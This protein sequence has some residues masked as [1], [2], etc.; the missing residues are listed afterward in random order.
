MRRSC[1]FLIEEDMKMQ[2]HL[3]H[4]NSGVALI[5]VLGM[6]AILMISAVAFS[7]SMRV[8]RRGASNYRYGVQSR[9]MMWS[10]LA[11]AMRDIDSAM[12]SSV[13]PII[14]PNFDVRVSTGSTERAN[15]LSIDV[16]NSLPLGLYNAK[17][18]TAKPY[19]L[20]ISTATGLQVGRYAYVAV[21]C[22]GLLD[23]NA[24][25]G[26]SHSNGVSPKEIQLDNLKDFL[27][28]SDFVGDRTKAYRYESF[29]ELNNTNLCKRDASVPL[30]N[31]CTYSRSREDELYSATG[32]IAKVDLSGDV[33]AIIS[34][35]T[36]IITGLT[37]C[38]VA[39]A[40]V[41]LVFSNLVDYIDT[42]CIPSDLASPCAEAV[43][44]ISEFFITNRLYSIASNSVRLLSLPFVEICYPFT[45]S[46]PYSFELYLDWKVTMSNLTTGVGASTEKT[47]MA[48]SPPGGSYGPLDRVMFVKCPRAGTF[49]SVNTTVPANTGDEIRVSYSV[50]AWVKERAS[51]KDVDYVPY[52]T[53]APHTNG[54]LSIPSAGYLSFSA[55]NL[56]PPGY[57]SKVADLETVDPRFNWQAGP[58][59]W[60]NST[61]DTLGTTNNL[62]KK[63][64]DDITRA[65]DDGMEMYVS[66]AGHFNS[67]GE[68]GNIL[69]GVV[70]SKNLFKTLHIF[71]RGDGYHARDRVLENFTLSPSNATYQ[72][73]VN[74]NTLNTNVLAS[75]IMGTPLGYADPR[76]FFTKRVTEIDAERIAAKI[77]S[78]TNQYYDVGEIG[79]DRMGWSTLLP[80]MSD[81]E[82]EAVISQIAGL[83]TVRGNM[84][85]VII[86]AD[87]FS[88]GMAGGKGKVL[89]SSRAIVEL[90]RDPFRDPSSGLHKWFIR[91]FKLL[92]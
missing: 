89:A 76:S 33:S 18:K 13:P 40:D 77:V 49:T 26:I 9:H 37:N 67:V 52:A 19:W 46:T 27:A 45:K 66:D 64:L 88:L 29:K 16:K 38:G 72:G 4:N 73:H 59:F 31:F 91:S 60:Y 6:L 65:A 24:V 70:P 55:T 7:I 41:D 83:L 8:E 50:K 10:G 63:Y 86:G 21:N 85:T 84:F 54:F 47:E 28:M 57:I 58:P 2:R 32:G 61:N 1:P 90:W 81:C 78:K 71:G 74:L 68:L 53:T 62:T 39:V 17:V 22:S 48:P 12:D 75:V 87:S 5:I 79:D 11:L 25:G 34:N 3:K 35:K 56:P 69:R 82:R 92:E 51:G 23:A 42:N 30:E 14:Y 15:V 43:P 44:M 20:P 36:R 80:D